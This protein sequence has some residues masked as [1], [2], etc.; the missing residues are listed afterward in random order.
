MELHSL[1]VPAVAQAHNGA[2]AVFFGGPGA[3]FQFRGKI[4]FFDDE[5]MIA[6][7][8]HRHGKTLKDGFVVV[9]HCAGL[10]MHDMTGANHA[11]AEGFADC[12]VTQTDSE[13]RNL[14]C[15][16]ADQID[17]DARLMRRARTGREDNP[18]GPQLLDLA[19]RN[20][21]V[22][23]DFHLC[24]QLADVLDQVV[25]ERIVV[26]E[27]ENQRALTPDYQ[28][29]P[30]RLQFMQICRLQIPCPAWFQSAI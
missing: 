10:A 4:F 22:A 6:S 25:S 5:R 20:L 21:I 23:A 26:V 9:H 16:M 18:S 30:E 3:D 1:C 13:H 27:Y 17:A 29:T 15:K 7:G 24:S 11:A 12:L 19:H 14:P 28:L 2:G 8:R